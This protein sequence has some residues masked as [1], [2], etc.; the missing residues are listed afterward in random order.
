MLHTSAIASANKFISFDL[1][2][3]PFMAVS[4]LVTYMEYPLSIRILNLA[5]YHTPIVLCG[6]WFYRYWYRFRFGDTEYLDAV[7]MMKRISCLW[8]AANLINWA[9]I[10]A[11][12]FYF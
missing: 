1:A 7:H 3:V 10:I 12:T 5:L 8:V 4:V 9:F 6:K 2:V 11:Q